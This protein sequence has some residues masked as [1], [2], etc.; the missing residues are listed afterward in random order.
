MLTAAQ[1]AY[2]HEGWRN[3]ET[4][5]SCRIHRHRLATGRFGLSSRVSSGIRGPCA[6]SPVALGHRRA[7]LVRGLELREAE[8]RRPPRRAAVQDE[9]PYHLLALA[10]LARGE[11]RSAPAYCLY[12]DL[13]QVVGGRGESRRANSSHDRPRVF[14]GAEASSADEALIPSGSEQDADELTLAPAMSRSFAAPNPL[15]RSRPR[16]CQSR[17]RG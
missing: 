13:R 17:P 7:H 12:V 6:A 3:T 11:E 10:V 1:S 2:C 4:N 16:R 5:C 9:E 8:A 14:E 15:S